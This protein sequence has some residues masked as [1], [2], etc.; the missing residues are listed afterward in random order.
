MP[1]PTATCFTHAVSDLILAYFYN[2]TQARVYPSPAPAPP[3]ASHLL[4][5][6]QEADHLAS[7]GVG[8]SVEVNVGARGAGGAVRGK[9]GQSIVSTV[10]VGQLTKVLKPLLAAQLKRQE[11]LEL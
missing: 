9:A 7:T 2:P 10:V 1:L 8:G 6:H 11:G 4:G 5:A 3:D